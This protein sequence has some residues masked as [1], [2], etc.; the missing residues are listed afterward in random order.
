[1]NHHR[2]KEKGVYLSVFREQRFHK[3]F[4]DRKKKARR[5]APPGLS[6]SLG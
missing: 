5:E 6:R 4:W 3:N 1:M 2:K